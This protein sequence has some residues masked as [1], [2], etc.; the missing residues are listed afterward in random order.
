MVDVLESAAGRT[1]I[2]Q[3][4]KDVKEV[5]GAGQQQ[6]RY[7]PAKVAAYHGCLWGYTAVEW[8]AWSK[9][10]AELCDRSASPWDP[11]ARRPSHADRRK[12]LQ[13][14]LLEG[15]FWRC[16]GERPCPPEIR[17]RVDFLLKRA[18]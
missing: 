4:F 7:G 9:P 14:E 1:S 3:T 15:E 11:E 10:F 16:W 12:A 17:E 6:L 2:E 8:W 13:R 18:G 5:E